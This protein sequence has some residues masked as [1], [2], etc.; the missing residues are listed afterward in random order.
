MRPIHISC[1]MMSHKKVYRKW[2]WRSYQKNKP[3]IGKILQKK[4]KL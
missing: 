1:G 3:K 2:I 4:V